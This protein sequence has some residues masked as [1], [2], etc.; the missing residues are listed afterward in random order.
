ML[1]RSG[2]LKFN[3]CNN[4]VDVSRIPPRI[5]ITLQ[6]D[7]RRLLKTHD[8][9][10]DAR[11]LTDLLHYRLSASPSRAGL[12]LTP[13][14]ELAAA[15]GIARHQVRN[16]LD[17]LVELQVLTRKH[18]SGVYVRK[19]PD[20]L[21]RKARGLRRWR[22]LLT[23]DLLFAK[24]RTNPRLKADPSKVRLRMGVWWQESHP[25]E[26]VNLLWAGAV[27]QAK[28]LGHDLIF[29]D[30]APF[31]SQEEK[32][33]TLQESPDFL[34]CDGH[35]I[36][37]PLAQVY[38]EAKGERNLPAV[39]I[40]P[41]MC[42]PS[43]QPLI[44][45]DAN[46]ALTES[47]RH[48]AEAGCRRIALL[49]LDI[50]DQAE[51]PFIKSQQSRFDPVYASTTKSMGLR[52]QRSAYSRPDAR[53][54]AE[55]VHFLLSEGEAFDGLVVGDD[56]VLEHALPALESRGLRPGVDIALI[57]FSNH[58]RG[59]PPGYRW[60]RMEFHPY[61]LGRLAVQ[62]LVKDIQSAGEDL[63]SFSH[64]PQWI[65]G[66]THRPSNLVAA[67]SRQPSTRIC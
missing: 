38:F 21:P 4:V 6:V 57:T 23:P 30:M 28:D 11:Q 34:H 59:L 45:I 5:D 29:H 37:V 12:R 19:V 32:T 43:L 1:V 18:G 24:S 54:A 53:S 60:S 14:R 62:C 41:G 8:E 2:A 61:Q 7:K 33:R 44:R 13:E 55:A 17:N 3:Q 25:S 67:G 36:L 40:W 65:S 58:G 46:E 56:V 26:S 47:M 22:S 66:E 16:A 39:F 27:D 64:Q 49:G 9:P 42:D 48:L 15:M 50:S 51:L 35:L 52:Y 63:L 10:I 20:P 31:E